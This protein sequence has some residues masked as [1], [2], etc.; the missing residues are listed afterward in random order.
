VNQDWQSIERRYR[1]AEQAIL[2]NRYDA[3]IPLLEQLTQ[4]YPTEP[5]FHWRLGYVHLDN[6]N[7]ISAVESFNRAIQLDS[8]SA[9]AWGGLGQAYM[10]L[11]EWDKAEHAITRRIQLKPAPNHFVF[12]AEIFCE[13]GDL[14]ASIRAC[15]DALALDPQFDEAWYNLGVYYHMLRLYPQA[16]EAFRKAISLDPSYAQLVEKIDQDGL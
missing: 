3:A 11:A 7:P 2:E 1:L 12:L 16:Q 6:G 4:D 15:L 13:K 14:E 8:A 5:L 10:A 9:P